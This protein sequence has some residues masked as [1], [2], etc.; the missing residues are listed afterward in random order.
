V[1][2]AGLVAVGAV[3][4]VLTHWLRL[5]PLGFQAPGAVRFEDF[6]DL[7][8]PYVVLGPA[9]AVLARR[10]VGRRS[11][12]VA[13]LGSV[14]FVQGHGL[15]LSANSISYAGGEAPPAYLWDEVVGHHL[16]FVG[17]TV[18]VVVV[19]QALRT[20]PVPV[21]PPACVLAGLVGLT[22][23]ANVVEGGIV[24]VGAALAAGLAV[25]GWRTRRSGAGRLLGL[26]F[27]L[28]LVL[29]A[30]YG[31]LLGGYPQPSDLGWL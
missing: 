11:W 23:A 16:W 2:V 12:A 18:V 22:W 14:A 4:M 25:Y 31:V 15:H 17:L 28:S 29:V 24:P 7:L 27:G 1:S 21:R 8:T 30:A 20:S 3:A 26:A 6:V 10:R 13:L 19:A 9:L 5:L